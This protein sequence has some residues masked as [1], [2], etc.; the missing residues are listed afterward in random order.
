VRS[1]LPTQLSPG[2]E[3]ICALCAVDHHAPALSAVLLSH[4]AQGRPMTRPPTATASGGASS[5]G[6]GSPATDVRPPGASASSSDCDGSAGTSP[7][8]RLDEQEGSRRAS[9]RGNDDNR[10]ARTGGHKGGRSTARRWRQV[11]A[12]RDTAPLLLGLLVGV[13]VC[14]PMFGGRPLFLLDW[15]AG[16]QQAW[17]ST[18]MLGLD[19]G[20]TAG[21]AGGVVMTLLVRSIGEAVTWLVLLVFFPLAAVGAGRLVGGWHSGRLGGGWPWGRVAAATLYCVNPWVFNRIYAGQLML[22]IGYA[23]LPFAVASALRATSSWPARR[24]A[25][26]G[27]PGSDGAGNAG[28]DERDTARTAP[29]PV[30]AGSPPTDSVHEPAQRW[31]GRLA[32]V[33][34]WAALTAISPHYV[35]IYGLVLVAV[36]V[37]TRPWTWRLVAWLATSAAAMVVLSLYIL[38]PHTATELPTTVGTVSLDIYR[39][40]ADPHLGLLPNVAA[41]YGFWRL[42]PGPVLPKDVVTGWPLLMAAMLVVIVAGYLAACSGTHVAAEHP[43]V[44]HEGVSTSAG[45]SRR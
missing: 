9:A 26:P 34:W 23:L 40:S 41:L 37:V 22:L 18:T 14:W 8:E 21:V 42:G 32:P 24:Q 6:S 2:I 17:P 20:L 44:A 29:A 35:W 1:P 19:G 12:H 39:T 4:V 33:L 16:P 7:G 15:V 38:L 13:G 3:H 45:T 5:A 43:R 27:S 11:A 36:V 30:V 31:S 25:R 10:G 28:P